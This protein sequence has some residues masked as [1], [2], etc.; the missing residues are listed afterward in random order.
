MFNFGTLLVQVSM[1]RVPIVKHLV[2]CGSLW[3]EFGGVCLTCIINSRFRGG[4]FVYG[5]ALD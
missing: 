1:S 4:R 2:Q 5:S 3:V